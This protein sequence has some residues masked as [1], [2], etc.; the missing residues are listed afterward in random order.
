[1]KLLKII[2][3]SAIKRLVCSRDV[4]SHDNGCSTNEGQT[5]DTS[6]LES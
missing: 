5:T 1:M 4:G 6:S 3:Y 2:I